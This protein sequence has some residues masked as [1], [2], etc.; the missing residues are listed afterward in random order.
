[1]NRILLSIYP[2]FAEKILTG[3]KKW[4]DFRSEYLLEYPDS[5]DGDPWIWLIQFRV[6]EL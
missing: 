2:E 4:E 1:M 6:I 5:K 3:E